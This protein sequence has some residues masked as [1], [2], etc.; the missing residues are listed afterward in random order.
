MYACHP[1]LCPLK[2]KI[3]IGIIKG[4]R[5]LKHKNFPM[6]GVPLRRTNSK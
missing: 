6:K 4:N 1:V 2:R 3:S 5:T